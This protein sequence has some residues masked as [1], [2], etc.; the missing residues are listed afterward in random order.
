MNYARVEDFEFLVKNKS[1]NLHGKVAIARY[2][3]IF[4]GDKVRYRNF[5]KPFKL[6]E[7]KRIDSY[8]ENYQLEGHWHP[9][10]PFVNEATK[11]T[12]PPSRFKRWL[13]IKYSTLQNSFIIMIY[14]FDRSVTDSR[15]LHWSQRVSLQLIGKFFFLETF[16][17]KRRDL[18]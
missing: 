7:W 13:F 15:L 6:F 9:A 17:I 5:D 12:K 1:L 4:R 8:N 16:V 10:I 3:K 18:T 2:G 11:E 14:D